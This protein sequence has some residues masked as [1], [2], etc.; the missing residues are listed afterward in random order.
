MEVN[1]KLII[2]SILTLLILTSCNK[3]EKKELEKDTA[4][5]E[6]QD[7][8]FLDE[9]ENKTT[10]IDYKVSE[11]SPKVSDY[12]VADDFSNVENI[13]NFGDFTDRQKEML[14]KNFFVITKPRNSEYV[15]YSDDGWDYRFDQ[16]HQIYEDNE[17]KYIPNFV[18]TDSVTHIFHI[19]YDGFLRNL[20]K[21]ELYPKAIEL[22]KN[23]LAENIELYNETT[24]I[25]LRSYS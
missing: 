8:K 20:E 9:M 13:N 10:Y 14:R 3:S 7:T 11:F 6:L 15:I 1:K 18:T 16:I 23:L 12:K 4:K 21:E 2:F 19:F 25:Q 24:I 17:Y 5:I 22:N